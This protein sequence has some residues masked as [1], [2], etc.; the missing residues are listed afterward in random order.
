MRKQAAVISAD[1]W[2]NLERRI[3]KKMNPEQ[4]SWLASGIDFDGCISG[5]SSTTR[6]V[7]VCISNKDLRPKEYAKQITG[8]GKIGA[9]HWSLTTKKEQL[10]VLKQVTPYLILKREL[11]EHALAYL[12]ERG[13]K[14]DPYSAKEKLLWNDF[15]ALFR[16]KHKRE[17]PIPRTFAGVVPTLSV[18]NCAWLAAAI[19]FDGYIS[20]AGHTQGITLGVSNSEDRLLL[21]T[22][23][24][25]KVGIINNIGWYVRNFDAV[26]AILKQVIPYM[27][28][29]QKLAEAVLNYLELRMPRYHKPYS[30]EETTLWKEVIK[31]RRKHK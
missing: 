20:P 23:T 17:R 2:N 15:D 11:A 9:I 27:I 19:D 8:V 10:S 30:E 1:E 22:G 26:Y 18:E 21:H 16:S 5:L 4:C 31:L 7:Y 29:K 24:I 6:V 3:V 28:I 25:T 13:E 12:I 14:K